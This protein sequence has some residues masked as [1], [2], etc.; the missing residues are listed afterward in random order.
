MDEVNERISIGDVNE[1]T[2]IFGELVN[3]M[4]PGIRVRHFLVDG[5]GSMREPPWSDSNNISLLFHA[6]QQQ[7]LETI[8][9]ENIGIFADDERSGPFPIR[10]LTR[11]LCSE[12]CRLSLKNLK[13]IDCILDG[14]NEDWEEFALANNNLPELDQFVLDT[15]DC[16]LDYPLE[17][18]DRFGAILPCNSP[19]LTSAIVD[20][21][22]TRGYID[23]GAAR[24]MCRLPQLRRLC[25][26]EMAFPGE[27][28][29]TMF[30]TLAQQSPTGCFTSH[31]E[32]L[33]LGVCDM[34][35]VAVQAFSSPGAVKDEGAFIAIMEA[36][37]RNRTIRCLDF[38]WSE[39]AWL[40][41][42]TPKYGASAL[43]AYHDMIRSNCTLLAMYVVDHSLYCG[44]LR[45]MK[46]FY[47][48]LNQIGRQRFLEAGNFVSD[49]E[50]LDK[51]V[52]VGRE[53]ENDH[54]N[55]LSFVYYFLRLNPLICVQHSASSN[56]RV[57]LPPN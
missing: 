19:K 7:P 8:S 22:K 18:F 51:L 3:Q 45:S 4:A 43:A 24:R 44:D 1:D 48:R 35:A 31:L 27:T 9:L 36:L 25:L 28:T 56:T 30:Q 23:L 21:A 39:K 55:A 12:S 13:L 34:D 41:Q 47:A 37:K 53:R 49:E 46:M 14:T 50:W 40:V 15:C 6:L 57:L 52:A 16:A 2:A 42:P 17:Q 29:A 26:F 54:Y 32:T 20:P 33:K 10:L 5:F 11:L 38:R